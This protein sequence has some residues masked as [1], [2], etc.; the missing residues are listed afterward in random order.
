MT[1]SIGDQDL[2]DGDLNYLAIGRESIFARC[3]KTT[4]EPNP[5][6]PAARL[7]AV[8]EPSTAAPMS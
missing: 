1:R 4:A 3:T 8:V 6:S 2:T 5:S 7:E